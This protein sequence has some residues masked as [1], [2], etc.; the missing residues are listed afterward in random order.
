M[1]P[2]IKEIY[3][4]LPHIFKRFVE[5]IY[6]KKLFEEELRSKNVLDVFDELILNFLNALMKEGLFY[7]RETL[8]DSVLWEYVTSPGY[9]EIWLMECPSKKSLPIYF[10]AQYHS[11]YHELYINSILGIR[12]P[13]MLLKIKLQDI[14]RIHLHP[15][16]WSIKA[17][18]SK[19][20]I[21]QV[22][23]EKFKRVFITKSFNRLSPNYLICLY[24]SSCPNTFKSIKYKA[25]GRRELS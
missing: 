6:F 20:G 5:R 25:L 22:N 9:L 14:V 1:P 18:P 8:R 13:R 2:E 12:N 17:R 23:V 24:E 4:N 19:K 16:L 15:P 10:L 3:L 21:L 11:K 7:T